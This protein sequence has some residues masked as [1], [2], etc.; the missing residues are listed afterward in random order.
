MELGEER[1]TGSMRNS[2]GAGV[3]SGSSGWP[4]DAVAG[5]AM[6]SIQAATSR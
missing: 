3:G 1:R 6:R 2:R 5:D 4:V